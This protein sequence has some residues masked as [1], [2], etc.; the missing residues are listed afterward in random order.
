MEKFLIVSAVLLISLLPLALFGR[1][2]WRWLRQASLVAE[3]TEETIRLSDLAGGL[4]KVVAEKEDFQHRYSC[5]LDNWETA[6]RRIDELE[7]ASRTDHQTIGDLHQQLAKAKRQLASEKSKV[8][9]LRKL[10][11]VPAPKKRGDRK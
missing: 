4:R 3:L 11:G 9:K 2:F 5:I 1:R 8:T 6:R 10:A 7:S